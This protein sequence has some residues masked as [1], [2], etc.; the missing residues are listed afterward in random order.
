MQRQQGMG[1]MRYFYTECFLYA[2]ARLFLQYSHLDI[3]KQLERLHELQSN[4]GSP[5][6]LSPQVGVA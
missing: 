3:R 5:V 4:A 1:L 6:K 2:C